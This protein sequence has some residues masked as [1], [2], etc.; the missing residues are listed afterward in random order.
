M[1]FR[2]LDGIPI[3]KLKEKYAVLIFQDKKDFQEEMLEAKETIF[4]DN[5]KAYLIK[6]NSCFVIF[7]DE[8]QFLDEWRNEYGEYKESESVKYSKTR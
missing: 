2:K 6:G 8:P 7:F 3:S 1:K 4:F 5:K